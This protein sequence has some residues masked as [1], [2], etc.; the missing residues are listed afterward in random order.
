MHFLNKTRTAYASEK[1]DARFL[2]CSLYCSTWRMLDKNS[3][4]EVI[5]LINKVSIDFLQFCTNYNLAFPLKKFLWKYNMCT[6][7]G[8][9]V[10]VW[11]IFT[12]EHTCVTNTQQET[13][14]FQHLRKCPCVSQSKHWK[15]PKKTTILTSN[16]GDEFCLFHRFLHMEL[17]SIIQYQYRTFWSL[18]KLPR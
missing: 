7:N 15:T 12:N 10:A 14:Y 2:G 13:E 9:S 16:A 5:I 17:Y 1:R 3:L 18:L 11:W 8:L 6:E 4:I